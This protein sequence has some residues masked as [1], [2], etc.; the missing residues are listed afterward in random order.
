[1]GPVTGSALRNQCQRAFLAAL[2]NG[3]GMTTFKCCLNKE[4]PRGSIHTHLTRFWDFVREAA[5]DEP[6]GVD[7]ALETTFAMTAS[8]RVPVTLMIWSNSAPHPFP[9]DPSY[10]FLQGPWGGGFL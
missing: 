10:V 5:K 3:D 4:R 6:A 7:L 8:L 2:H 9:L 1:M